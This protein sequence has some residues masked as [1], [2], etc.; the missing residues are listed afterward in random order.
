ML[1]SGVK[2]A[3]VVTFALVVSLAIPVVVS[4]AGCINYGAISGG[5][6][7]DAG[8]PSVKDASAAF[9]SSYSPAMWSAFFCSDFDE[10][11]VQGPWQTIAQTGA[12]LTQTSTAWVSPP[13][14]LD[15]LV[16]SLEATTSLN[17]GLRTP[18]TFPT[19]F[20]TTMKFSASIEPVQIDTQDQAT[21]VL[22]AIDFIDSA[23]SRYSV[24]LS[25]VVLDG[26]LT[27]E[28]GE[29]S[30]LAD[31]G[32]LDP[33]KDDPLPTSVTLPLNAFSAIGIEIDWSGPT[34]ARASVSVNGNVEL[35]VTLTVAVTAT[36]MD[37]GIGTTYVHPTPSSV[38]E[39]R[40]DN[41]LFTAD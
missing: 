13:N 15:E 8:A 16:P 25:G 28:L 2:R 19:S 29:S 11:G 35:N 18:V 37:I 30:A 23:Q 32:A 4:L 38:W 34:T 41:V 36:N 39:L 40:Y 22:D 5:A 14:S 21:I 20:P 24:V 10:G 1:R 12:T 9:C 27:L 7:P 3:V 33:F 31:G 26:G 6:T 17:V